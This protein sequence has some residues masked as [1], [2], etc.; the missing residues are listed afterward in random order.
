MTLPTITPRNITQRFSEDTR[1]GLY[2]VIGSG[3]VTEASI[4]TGGLLGYT[5][6]AGKK[7]RM[8]GSLMVTDLGTN[9]QIRV[10]VFD[11]TAGRIVPI[12]ISTAVGLQINWSTV[13]AGAQF[14][15]TIN[16]DNAANDGAAA[17]LAS[18]EELP[19]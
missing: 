12:A 15:I 5:I 6:P 11:S 9:T 3:G 4:S 19:A 14:T 8:R 2:T 1:G 10:N 7:T 18:I 17:I 16:G 13:L